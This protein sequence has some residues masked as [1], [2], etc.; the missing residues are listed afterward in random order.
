MVRADG[1]PGPRGSPWPPCLRESTGGP[2]GDR[3]AGLRRARSLSPRVGA[4][5]APPC[6]PRF[7]ADAAGT[8]V[9]RLDRR[10]SPKS[11]LSARG[12]S[13]RSPAGSWRGLGW[14]R[15][16]LDLDGAGTVSRSTRTGSKV[17]ARVKV[18]S[19]DVCCIAFGEGDVWL[20]ISG[21]TPWID[22]KTNSVIDRIPSP[23]PSRHRCRPWICL[24]RARARRDSRANRSGKA[25]ARREGSRRPGRVNWTT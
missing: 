23:R 18:G 13:R 14:C 2:G 10:R 22:A 20:S 15:R 16:R 4:S 19:P 7:L 5:C 12:W 24:G 9:S 25:R 11:L 17:V 3:P 1:R 8:T 6:L 21:G